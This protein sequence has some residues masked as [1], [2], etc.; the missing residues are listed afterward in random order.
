MIQAAQDREGD[1]LATC[2]MGRHGSSFRLGELLSDP[3]MRP[4]LVEVAYIRV[5]H[6]VE[7]L[8]MQDEQMIEA[9]TPY[10]AEEALT[11]GIRPRGVIRS[12]ENLDVTR[13]SNPSEAHT[14]FA[15]VI[16]DEVLRSHTKGG[17]EPSL[18]CSPSVSGIACHAD[19]DHSA[20]VQFDN[21]EGKKRA[22]EEVS[23]RKKIA[24][25]DLL[26]MRVQEGVPLLSSW[27]CSA[28]GS[29]VLLNSPLADV[30]TQLE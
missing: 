15:V 13:R 12:F 20:R 28:H 16:T 30:K 24:G 1:D 19:V 22:E 27:P 29:H 9:L 2:V 21:E 25:P 10:T 17:G 4:G 8:L 18:L 3:L 14:K 11:D 6:A 23:D 7:L 5:E 26:S